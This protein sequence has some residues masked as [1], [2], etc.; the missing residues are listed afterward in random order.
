MLG[1]GGMVLV[2]LASVFDNA[3]HD[4]LRGFPIVMQSQDNSHRTLD[5]GE[6]R[7]RASGDL[8]RHCNG[9]IY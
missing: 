3:N 6:Y 7:F 4:V 9:C 5:A 2:W 8:D 1:Q